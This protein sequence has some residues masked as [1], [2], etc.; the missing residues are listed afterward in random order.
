MIVLNINSKLTQFAENTNLISLVNKFMLCNLTFV[1]W[2]CQIGSMMELNQ[3]ASQLDRRY[4]KYTDLVIEK[5]SS[6]VHQMTL[7]KLRDQ[8][9]LQKGVFHWQ[10]DLGLK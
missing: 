10:C 5:G 1:I 8:K 9:Q 3:R 6:T 2:G 7:A 4:Q